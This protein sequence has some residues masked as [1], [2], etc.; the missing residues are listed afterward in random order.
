MSQE[1]FNWIWLILLFCII[2]MRKIHERKSGR[3]IRLK[4][5]IIEAG[6][7]ILWGIAAGILP[8]FYLFGNLLD[9]ANIEMHPVF[10]F[11]GTAI[12]LLAIWLLHRSHTD[13]GKLWKTT[14][15]PEPGQRLITD[16]IYKRIR[17]PMYTAHVLW[18]VAQALLLPNLIAGP[19]ALLLILAIISIRVPR[20]ERAMLEE[21]G[22]EYQR[23]MDKT[24]GILPKIK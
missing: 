23:Y 8:F 21:F 5:P 19:L 13:L 4:A 7:M 14:V 18:G 24:G 9:F 6:L 10:G 3:Q 20:E 17:H 1:T 16:G 12:F 2:V 22:G 11:V 15:E